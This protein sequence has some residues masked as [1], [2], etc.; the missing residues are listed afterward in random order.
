[1]KTEITKPSGFKPITV[2]FTFETEQELINMY[3]KLNAPTNSICKYGPHGKE[4]TTNGEIEMYD[5]ISQAY[6]DRFK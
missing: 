3:A 2:S 1:M 6:D 5:A 4:V